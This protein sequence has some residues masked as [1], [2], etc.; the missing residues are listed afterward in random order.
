M[1]PVKQ[2]SLSLEHAE[3]ELGM[4]DSIEAKSTFCSS[5]L[6]RVLERTNL[7]R[8]LKQVRRNKGAPGIDGMTVDELPDF[9]REHWPRI[10]QQLINGVY[11]PKPVK[12]VEIPKPDGG[13]RKLGIPTVLDRLIQQAI[14]QVLQ[15]E[16]EHDFH[17]NSY[18][19]RPNRNAHQALHYAQDTIQQGYRWVVDCDLEAFFDGVNH[20][21]LMTQ[22]KDKHQDPA[23]LRLVNRYLKAGVRIDGATQA[24]VEGVPQGGPLSPIL[25]NIVLNQLDWELTARG[26]R[27]VRY[28]DDVNIIVGS[29]RAGQRAMTSITRFI[30]GRLRLTVNAS[31]SA[32]AR[33]EDRH[34][35]GFS[36]RVDSK[37]GTVR[38]MLSRRT[39][40]RAKQ[41]LLELTP[42]NWGASLRRCISQ[43]NVYLRGWYGFFR[44]C[45]PA[46]DYQLRN[47]DSLLRRRL[48]AIQLRHWKRKR[49]I[50]RNLIRRGLRRRTAWRSVYA[51]R[52]SFWALSNTRA[53]V[54]ALPKKLFTEL[55]LVS[56][57]NVHRLRTEALA[58]PKQLAL[59]GIC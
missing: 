20:D 18:G 42:R 55:G 51:G 40:K 41:R 53:T 45:S 37:D 4:G 52:Q 28:A 25:S 5:L 8:A 57:A 27:F 24:S 49:T 11:R 46:A 58:A 26:H 35:L 23:L 31:K 13:K 17:D 54:L 16:W 9:L 19:F 21:L 14:A 2:L 34:F 29:E 56:L 10:R 59:F 44:I 1:A 50:V 22:L 33:P 48:R 32:V 38:V 7:V 30:E 39:M 36:L 43:V 47:L 3:G 15:E 6:N 12:R